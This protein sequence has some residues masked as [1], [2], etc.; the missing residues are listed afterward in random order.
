MRALGAKA[1]LYIDAA[2]D[3]RPSQIVGRARRLLPPRVLGAWTR[4][5]AT[6]EWRPNAGGI[7]AE[8]EPQGGP[9]PPPEVTGEFAAVGASRVWG[10][11]GFWTDPSDG[12]LYL[13]HLHDFAALATYAASQHSRSGDS[14]WAQV[15][16]SWLKSESRPRL[17]SWHPYPTSIRVISWAAALSSIEGWPDTLRSRMAAELWRQ[18]RYLRRSIEYDI[19]GNHVLK[20]ATALVAAGAVFESSDL[21][22]SGLGLLRRELA[23]QILPDGGHEERSTSYHRQVRHDLEDAAELA[24]RLTGS[25][26][27]WLLD[28]LRRSTEWEMEMRGP[29][30]VLPLL[31]D[32]WEGPPETERGTAPVTDLRDSGY[33]VLRDGD[34]QAIFDVG[35]I[36]PPHLPPHAHADALS[37]VAWADGRQLVVDP[38]SYYY[39]GEWRDRFRGTA[40]HNTVEVDGRDQCQFWGDFRAAH[41]PRVL[42]QPLRRQGDVVVTAG[43][44]DGYRRLAEPVTHH[45]SLVW[46]PGDGLVVVDVLRGRG[47]HEVR[48]SLHLAPGQCACFPEHR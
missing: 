11:P 27:D 30:G 29:D 28:A 4:P 46:C 35:R 6:P 24:R 38:G 43:A 33:V 1:P 25:P 8:R 39:T 26:P 34:N 12:L 31:N 2:R 45:R 37:F 48:S 22:G 16:E 13:F 42:A 21:L 23:R 20:N 18:A 7:G 47:R 3:M 19:G 17:P 9:A 41:Q 36:C 15:V 40:A 10:S 44:H 5:R 32:A 14:F